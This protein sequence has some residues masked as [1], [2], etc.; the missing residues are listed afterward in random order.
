[1]DVDSD[2]EPTPLSKPVHAVFTTEQ[3]G[4]HFNALMVE[5]LPAQEDLCCNFRLHN[6]HRLTEG[7]ITGEQANDNA[8]TDMWPCDHGFLNEQQALYQTIRRACEALFVVLRVV[9][10]AVAPLSRVV[11]MVKGHEE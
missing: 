3:V 5:E 11:N 6:E 7:R 1:M 9:V 8:V 2:Q 10:L 4:P